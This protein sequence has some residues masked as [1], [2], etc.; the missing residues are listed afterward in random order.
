MIT[1]EYCKK[2]KKHILWVMSALNKRTEERKER[3]QWSGLTYLNKSIPSPHIHLASLSRTN[4]V[5]QCDV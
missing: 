4:T 5:T 3:G 1:D 2:K